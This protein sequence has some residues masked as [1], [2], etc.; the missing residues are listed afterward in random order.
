MS[1]RRR[2]E[3]PTEPSANWSAGLTYDGPIKGISVGARG[4]EP[5]T[6]GTPYRCATGLRHAP[7]DSHCSRLDGPGRTRR[8]WACFEGITARNDGDEHVLRHLSFPG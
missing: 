2:S 3:P 8:L 4:F 6:T 5:P 7:S 1:I